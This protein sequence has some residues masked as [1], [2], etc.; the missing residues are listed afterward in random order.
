MKRVWCVVFP[1]LLLASGCEQR[2]GGGVEY[3]Y[4][5]GDTGP[6]GGLIFYI[7]EADAYIWTYLEAAPSTNEWSGLVWGDYG[8]EIGGSAGL[9]GVGDGQ[10]ATSAIVSHMDS[11]SITGTPAQLCDSLDVGSFSDWFLPSKDELNLMYVNLHQEGIGSFM[12]TGYSSSSEVDGNL[13]WYQD[14]V[15]GFQDTGTKNVGLRVRA[16]RAF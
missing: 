12:N 7:D 3:E 15:D 9:T 11:Q 13:V 1:L 5:L 16:V 8:M 10:T 2:G 14:F 4:A 6:A